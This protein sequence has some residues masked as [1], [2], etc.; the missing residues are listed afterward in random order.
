MIA[1]MICLELFLNMVISKPE[2]LRLYDGNRLL[3]AVPK[4]ILIVL[5]VLIVT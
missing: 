5:C 1:P 2:S 3:L 4:I